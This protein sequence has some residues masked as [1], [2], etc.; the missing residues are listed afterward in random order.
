MAQ[1]VAAAL[2]FLGLVTAELSAKE[3]K[4]DSHRAS[5]KGNGT[6]SLT[7]DSSYCSIS[8]TSGSS[9][10]P[11]RGEAAVLLNDFQID[12]GGESP[13]SVLNAQP[14]SSV[15]P[16][17]LLKAIAGAAI[18]TIPGP[19]SPLHQPAAKGVNGFLSSMFD[20]GKFSPRPEAQKLIDPLV[21][22]GCLNF[23]SSGF[24]FLLISRFSNMNGT[25]R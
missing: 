19:E 5:A 18:S 12:L 15:K 14:P 24:H 2:M 13:F 1:I 16:D 23:H 25:C 4:C 20:K 9:A 8:Y 7:E 21:K 10:S 11:E 3:C 22:S 6:C 17:V